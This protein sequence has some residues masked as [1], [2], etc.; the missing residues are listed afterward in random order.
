[1]SFDS[2]AFF[3]LQ[4]LE[5]RVEWKVE[6]Q[7]E[8]YVSLTIRRREK[9]WSSCFYSC[10]QTWKFWNRLRAWFCCLFHFI[11]F[12]LLMWFNWKCLQ[13]LQSLVDFLRPGS[14]CVLTRSSN[15]IG[16]CFPIQ[17][18]KFSL[19]SEA[20]F[21]ILSALHSTQQQNRIVVKWTLIHKRKLTLIRVK[22]EDFLTQDHTLP[23]VCLSSYRL[24]IPDFSS[25]CVACL[26]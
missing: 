4:S 24:R 16:L 11:L 13:V 23:N 15:S 19:L 21:L 10:S 17:C 2:L 14:S 18:K 22:R 5:N 1:M 8:L 7:L 12:V 25:L 20:L 9:L 6:Q 26:F 3:S